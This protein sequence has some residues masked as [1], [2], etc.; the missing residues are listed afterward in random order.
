MT[1]PS[2]FEAAYKKLVE[3]E[4]GYKLIDI[5]GDRGGKTFCGIT[6]RSHP[7]WGG[8]AIILAEGENS[9][10]LPRLVMDFYHEKYWAPVHADVFT[11]PENSALVFHYAV[12]AGVR[13]AARIMQVCVGVKSDG[14]V[15]PQTLAA[16]KD[17]EENRPGLFGPLFRLGQVA[18]YANICMRD[19]SQRKFLLGWINRALA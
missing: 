8:W 9:P 5:P 15:G 3:L 19:K 1:E 17:V 10:S 14:A 7:D 18:H 11:D 4:G 13:K 2:A 6:E 16:I 12:V